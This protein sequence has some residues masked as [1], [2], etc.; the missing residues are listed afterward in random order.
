MNEK[1]TVAIS[2]EHELRVAKLFEA[3][4][5]PRSGGGAW[6]KGDALAE[7]WFVECKTTTKPTA[8]YS[9]SKAVLD[10]A[11]HERAEMHKPYLALAFTIGE[12]YDDYFVVD[13]RTMS[14]MLE[15]RKG[16]RTL[17]GELRARLTSI[18][19]KKAQLEM[20]AGSA[21]A[22]LKRA[23]S[24]EEHASYIAHKGALSAFIAD[25]EKL[26]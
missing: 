23:L 12:A 24:S 16:V 14:A 17:I 25:L 1:S 15:Q 5:T 10:K 20:V 11:D 21:G 18:E 26:V 6:K 22:I 2:K 4:R 13:K 7:D 9:V 19:Q 8:S 3:N